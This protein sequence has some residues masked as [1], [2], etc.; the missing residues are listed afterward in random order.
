MAPPTSIEAAWDSTLVHLAGSE[1]VTGVKG[2]PVADWS[3]AVYNITSLANP[4]GAADP[5]GVAAATASIAAAV[6][7]LETTNSTVAG[8]MIVAPQ[9]TFKVDAQTVITNPNPNFTG[10]VIFQ[11]AGKLATILKPTTA[12]GGVSSVVKFLNSRDCS[13]RDMRILG[14]PSG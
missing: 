6:A 10:G 5:T 8:G 13:I 14:T 4:S 3:G 9:G 11:G 7:A 2:G 12:L 1:T